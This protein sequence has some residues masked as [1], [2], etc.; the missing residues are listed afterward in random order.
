M[1]YAV[2][3]EVDDEATHELC[4]YDEVRRTIRIVC[5]S[6]K[7]CSSLLTTFSKEQDETETAPNSP[8]G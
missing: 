8:Q 4:E 7:H 1:K 2:F 5:R 3:I 6:I